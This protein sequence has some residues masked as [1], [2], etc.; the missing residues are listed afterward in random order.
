MLHTK[1]RTQTVSH[2]IFFNEA[3]LDGQASAAIY[4][5]KK[6]KYRLYPVGYGKKFPWEVIEDD[7]IVVILDFY[8]DDSDMIVENYICHSEDNTVEKLSYVEQRSLYR[9]RDVMLAIL[10]EGGEDPS[11]RINNLL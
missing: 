9:S 3:Y 1:Q 2:R 8:P 4:A 11:S 5:L 7:D 6:N 10:Q